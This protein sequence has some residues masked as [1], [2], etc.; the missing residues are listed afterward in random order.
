[1]YVV[2]DDIENYANDHTQAEPELLQALEKETCDKMEMSRMLT[3]R[4]AGR[5]LNMLVAISGAK[6]ILEIGMF[7]GYSAL[8]MAE[9]L[10]E[11]GRIVTCDVDP[12]AQ[13]MAQK[14]FDKSHLGKKI[15]IK[16]GPALET[17][18]VL[19]E[20]F[21]GELDLVFLDA[22]KENYMHYYE[23]VL[24]KLKQGG[25]IVVDNCLWSGR[26]LNPQQQTDRSIAELN[27]KIANDQ[28]VQNVMLTVRDGMNLV[29]KL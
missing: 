25:L 6:N 27:A 21:D 8:S 9:A 16:M 14:Y 1:M 28:R 18:A 17:I 19:D 15:T 20:L 3:G 24:P 10:P 29:R 23:A 12:E 22:D 26:V 4:L 13:V 7:T 2:A 5:F 11:D